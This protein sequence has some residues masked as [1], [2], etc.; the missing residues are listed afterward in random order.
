MIFTQPKLF[1]WFL[2]DSNQSLSF[3][4]ASEPIVQDLSAK[5]EVPNVPVTVTKIGY[6]SEYSIDKRLFQR[7]LFELYMNRNPGTWADFFDKYSLAKLVIG[8]AGQKILHLLPKPEDLPNN[9]Q[10]LRTIICKIIS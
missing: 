9:F 4:K 2:D 7:A 5:D 3:A 10:T 1:V 8:R 6:N